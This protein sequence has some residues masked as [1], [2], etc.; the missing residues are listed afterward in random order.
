MQKFDSETGDTPL[1]C[2]YSRLRP[3]GQSSG[4]LI[5]FPLNCLWTVFHLSHLHLHVRK[6]YK[7]PIFNYPKRLVPDLNPYSPLI[8]SSFDTY[9]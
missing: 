4:D 8:Q 7:I 6:S 1:S 9:V 5:G 3:L 2:F